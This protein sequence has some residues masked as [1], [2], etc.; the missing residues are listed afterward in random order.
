MLNQKSAWYDVEPMD[1]E[2]Q[3][4]GQRHDGHLMTDKSED[5]PVHYLV[6]K[7]DFVACFHSRSIDT[8]RHCYV[9]TELFV[10]HKFQLSRYLL[11]FIHS[12]GILEQ[13]SARK[14]K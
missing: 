3:V 1:Y 6:V 11:P 9:I 4:N 12:Y 7:I 5:I 14:K 8:R 10:D 2:N 13:H